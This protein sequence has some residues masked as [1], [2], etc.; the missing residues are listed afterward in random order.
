MT[1]HLP[2]PD[3]ENEPADQW[4]AIA[5]FLA[6]ESSA[7]EAAEMR[8]WFAENPGYA[9]IAESLD[10]MLPVASR[11]MV[12]TNSPFT[13][14]LAPVSA[15]EVE[16]ALLRVRARMETP[17]PILQLSKSDNSAQPR[18]LRNRTGAE[19]TIASTPKWSFGGW[20]MA[21]MAAAAAIALAVVGKQWMSSKAPV[22][23]LAVTYESKV[24][25]QDSITLPDSSQVVLAP[26]SKLIVAA[27]YGQG[28]RNVELQ[29]AGQFTV[30]H[31][32]RRPF[33]VRSGTA[34]IKDLGTKFIVKQT[35][36]AEVLVS[37]MEGSVSLT[38][39]SPN[40]Q[41]QPV[42]LK[43]G[44]RGR[45]PAK[46]NP[47]AELGAVTPEESAWL[48]GK[49]LYRDASLA[50]VQADL[51]RWYGV[52]LV[53]RDSLMASRSISADALAGEP[54]EKL[55]EKIAIMRGGVV[56]RSGDTAFINRSGDRPKH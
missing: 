9:K 1:D 33:S 25:V 6:G 32:A 42:E 10:A 39:A 7:A 11:D 51:L 17:A 49:L 41:G 29:G 24:G 20:Q 48:S 37:V 21:G 23:T 50:E 22:S 30:K 45:L 2:Q 31:D 44:D 52:Q 47:V 3:P 16:N 38:D 13:G 54:V 14:Q 27:N 35:A 12:D 40:A 36:K 56:V 55:L 18:V 43:A 5:R 15:T 26:G 34:L 8:Q 28:Q 46:G 19:G 53:V 4:S